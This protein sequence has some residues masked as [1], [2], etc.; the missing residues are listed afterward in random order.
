M[1]RPHFQYPWYRAS[2]PRAA[3]LKRFSV[4]RY[5]YSSV[6]HWF[7]NWGCGMRKMSKGCTGII[8][9]FKKRERCLK[10]TTNHYSQPS[11]T[12]LGTVLSCNVIEQ[13][14]VYWMGR[15]A[16]AASKVSKMEKTVV[17]GWIVA[18]GQREEFERVGSGWMVCS[19]AYYPQVHLK[20]KF[21]NFL[22]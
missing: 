19:G 21:E 14:D 5:R 7:L 20:T 16:I 12:H 15:L 1:H 2:T 17:G 4:F 6:K 18:R 13:H 9:V 10:V 22:P 11:R 8:D 3:S